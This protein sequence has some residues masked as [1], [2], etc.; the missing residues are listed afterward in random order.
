VKLLSL[1]SILLATCSLAAG[2]S[3]SKHAAD[4]QAASHLVDYD[5]KQPTDVHEKVIEQFEGGTLCDVTYVSPKGGPVDA[6]L[7]I[8]N[9]K[10]PLAGILFGHWGNGTRAEFIPKAKIYC[11]GARFPSS[12]IIRGTGHNRGI[13]PATILVSPNSTEIEIQAVVDL[14]RGNRLV[15]GSPRS[16][17]ETGPPISGT[18][19]GRSGDRSSPPWTSA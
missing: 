7:I 12:P 19:T 4:F 5:T 16:R 3:D 10:G 8:P 11:A 1:W 17:L 15:A 14:R 13:R 2:Q 9:G 18:A 6:Y